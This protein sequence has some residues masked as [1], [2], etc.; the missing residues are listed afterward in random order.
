MYPHSIQSRS[1]KNLRFC[2]SLSF[3]PP[4]LPPS[5]T[6]ATRSAAN[7]NM[8]NRSV[9]KAAHHLPANPCR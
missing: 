9:L 5:N 7:R 2:G 1:I 4:G 3:S 8:F 6:R